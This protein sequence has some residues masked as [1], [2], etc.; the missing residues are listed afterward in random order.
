M[1][2][3]FIGALGVSISGNSSTSSLK[4]TLVFFFGVLNLK[5]HCWATRAWNHNNQKLTIRT[6]QELE[7]RHQK[8]NIKRDTHTHGFF[9]CFGYLIKL[10]QI[11]MIQL[12]YNPHLRFNK[13][14]SKQK[15]ETIHHS[16]QKYNKK[17]SLNRP[18]Y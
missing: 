10:V 7:S 9:Y 2:I 13:K 4:K 1:D 14:K 18:R 5:C 16:N 3:G 8:N 12:T 17:L 6:Q 11:F 15:F